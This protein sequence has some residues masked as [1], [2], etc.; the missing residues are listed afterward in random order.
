MTSE[1]GY[2]HPELL[3]ET[4]WLGEHLHDPDL[5]IVDAGPPDAYR[6]AHIPGAVGI[7]AS[8]S[9]APPNYLK[10][11]SN[12]IHVMIPEQFQ[13]LME[14]LGIGNE[15]LVV[16]YDERGGLYAARLWW[17]LAYY[18][19]TRA[20]VLNGGWQKWLGEGR[21][22]ATDLPT[23]P[24]ARFTPRVQPEVLCTTQELKGCVGKQG[25]VILDVRS[26]G[27]Y[28]GA[29]PRQNKRAGHIPG[30]IHIEWLRNLT[31]E[32]TFRPA[33]ELRAMY[34]AAGVTP[35]KQIIAH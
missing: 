33:A 29:E 22:I 4:S 35:E 10:D 17:A 28:T 13:G 2:A 23:Y 19:H 12:G 7:P 25:T 14:E 30:A 24:R 16:G 8:S 6:R 27:E 11:P 3:A 9:P 34:E 15:T 20:K 21:P 26:E 1:R 32:L 5:R 31:P 18:G